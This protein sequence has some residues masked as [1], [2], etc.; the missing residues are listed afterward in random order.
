MVAAAFDVSCPHCHSLLTISPEA[1]A[2]VGH[3]EPRAPKPVADMDEAV[4]R[5]KQDP[6]RRES[7]FSQS[8]ETEKTKADRLKK[9]FDDLLRRTGESPDTSRPVRDLD[10]D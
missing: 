6:N 5:L 2:V 1:K 9:S 8:L 3:Q 7:L 10:L 4:Q